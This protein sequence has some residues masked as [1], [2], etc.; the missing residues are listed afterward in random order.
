[1]LLGLTFYASAQ[2]VPGRQL[3]WADYKGTPDAALPFKSYTMCNVTY[4]VSHPTRCDEEGHVRFTGVSTS[5]N[6]NPQSWIRDKDS[7]VP[8]HRTLLLSHEQG[9]YDLFKVY[10]LELKQLILTTCFDS[11]DYEEQ[12]EDLNHE[13]FLK[14][15]QLQRAYDEQTVHGT[16]LQQQAVWKQRIYNLYQ[17]AVNRSTT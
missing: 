15:D 2:Q 1:M 16:D 13:V 7:M 5:A 14:Y 9:H 12:L 4:K 11:D 8:S 6:F 3:R 17:A 10:S